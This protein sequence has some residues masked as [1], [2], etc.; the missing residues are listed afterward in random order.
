MTLFLTLL[1]NRWGQIIAVALAAFFYG[2]YSVPRVDV[3]AIVLNTEAARDAHWSR[4]LAQEKERYETHIKAA[5]AAA[6]QVDDTPADL[7]E[8]RRLCQQ[9]ATCRDKNG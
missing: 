6:E 9:S 4:Q 1:G 2:F 5:L 8:R 7:S 3:Q